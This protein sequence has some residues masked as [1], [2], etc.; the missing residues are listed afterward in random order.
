[1]KKLITLKF[2]TLIFS[3]IYLV[4]TTICVTELTDAGGEVDLFTISVL[5]L[6]FGSNPH[7]YGYTQIITKDFTDSSRQRHA[8]SINCV[9]QDMYPRRHSF[10]IDGRDILW[11]EID[12]QNQIR[13]IATSLTSLPE[14][15][16][17]HEFPPFAIGG[18]YEHSSNWS[19][20]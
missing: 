17:S 4:A 1:M 3:Q 5:E 16:L 13:G 18:G 15:R 11:V 7:E 9:L 12:D 6:D 2:L 8:I 19:M 10:S 20:G 14:E